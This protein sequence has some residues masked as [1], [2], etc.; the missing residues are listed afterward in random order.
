VELVPRRRRPD[1]FHECE[2]NDARRPP[3][4]EV[5]GKRGTPVLRDEHHVVDLQRVEEGIEIA[6]LIDEAIVDVRLA[7]LA[8]ADQVGRD[9]ARDGRDVRHD[10]PPD[11]RRSRIAVQEEDDRPIRARL[12]V[13]HRRVEHVD[14]G[15]A[16]NRGRRSCC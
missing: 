9:A 12:D 3:R 8:V 4:R 7:G 11:E 13:R 15:P 5:E 1:E 16:E 2:S 6:D 10:V 14:V